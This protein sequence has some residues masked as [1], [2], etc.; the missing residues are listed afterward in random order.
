ML[1]EII[2][3]SDYYN[4]IVSPFY[5]YSTG[6]TKRTTRSAMLSSRDI[7]DDGKIEIPQILIHLMELRPLI[8]NGMKIPFLSIQRIQSVLKKMIIRLS[9][10][11]ICLRKLRFGMIFPNRF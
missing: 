6:V 10:P 3:W 9:F 11:M 4:T 8:G 7:N 2:H 5:S 1:T